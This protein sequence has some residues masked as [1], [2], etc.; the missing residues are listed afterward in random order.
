VCTVNPPLRCGYSESSSVASVCGELAR[1][2]RPADRNDR[3]RFFC[4]AHRARGDREIRSD[5]AYQRVTLCCDVIFAGVSMEA[6]VAN[7]EALNR[8]ED[9]VRAQGGLINFHGAV[10]E[11]RHISPPPP[12]G[13]PNGDG[14]RGK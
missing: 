2:T 12:S 8:L 13:G 10:C 1:W 5:E 11:I 7:T 4:D 9:A 6:W 14:A 3:T